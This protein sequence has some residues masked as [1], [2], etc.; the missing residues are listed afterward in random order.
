MK[1]RVVILYVKILTAPELPWTEG[2][3]KN[4]GSLKLDYLEYLCI[5]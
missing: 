1:E 5:R 2:K 4:W 3:K